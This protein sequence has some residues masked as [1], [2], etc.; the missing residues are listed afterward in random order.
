MNQLTSEA[1][2][3]GGA[4]SLGCPHEQGCDLMLQLV[5]RLML[6]RV[7]IAMAAFFIRCNY[8][9]WWLVTLTWWRWQ[10]WVGAS[11]PAN[12]DGKREWEVRALRALHRLTVVVVFLVCYFVMGVMCV[13]VY[14]CVCVCVR[15][16]VPLVLW[17]LMGRASERWEL[18]TLVMLYL[19]VFFCCCFS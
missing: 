3:R 11:I 5:G 18:W 13:C 6:S 19:F 4:R 8:W 10:W 15:L 14:V 16:C 9:Y 17:I 1:A 12:A 2:N 7:V